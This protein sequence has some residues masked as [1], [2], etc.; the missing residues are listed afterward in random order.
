M[1]I[2][3]SRDPRHQ[4]YL[5]FD[6]VSNAGFGHDGGC[7][8]VLDFEATMDVSDMQ[9]TPPSWRMW[10]GMRSRTMTATALAASR[11]KLRL[12]LMMIAPR[13]FNSRCF[14]SLL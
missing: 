2:G 7:D 12:I 13:V 1:I 3:H 14:P 5:G 9:A 4:S 8:G 11:T 6:K 10:A